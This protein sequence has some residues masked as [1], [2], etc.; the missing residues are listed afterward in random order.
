MA[1]N[2]GTYLLDTT[3]YSVRYYDLPH[4]DTTTYPYMRLHATKDLI[5]ASKP[6]YL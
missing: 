6:G 1:M 3:A 4:F 5:G 2:R